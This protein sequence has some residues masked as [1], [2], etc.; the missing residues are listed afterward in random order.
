MADEMQCT[1]W[2]VDAGPRGPELITVKGRGLI[3]R[4]GAIFFADSLISEVAM[5]RV[6]AGRPINDSKRMALEQMSA[7]LVEQA[8]QCETV[9]RLR[10][11]VPVLCG[12]LCERSVVYCSL[13]ETAT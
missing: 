7:W 5:R 11:G 6:P 8:S 12:K 9:I 2:F 13:L 10:T 4:V 3:E 1:V